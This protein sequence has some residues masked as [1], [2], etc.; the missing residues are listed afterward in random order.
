MVAGSLIT[1]MPGTYREAAVTDRDMQTVGG[2]DRAGIVVQEADA[3]ATSVTA[4]RAAVR[5]LTVRAVG[6]KHGRCAVWLQRGQVVPVGCDLTSEN[7]AMVYVTR[8]DRAPIIRECVIRD[9]QASGVLVYEQGQG[10]IEPCVISGNAYPGVGNVPGGNPTVRGCEIGDRKEGG[11]LVVD[12]GEGTIE[13]CVISGNAITAWRSD[14]TASK[15]IRTDH[16]PN[17]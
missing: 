1:V 2:S 10:T 4:D 6:T 15:V 8:Q 11:V 13:R 14:H 16:T 9:R 12:Q 3:D 5:N 17:Q 7:G